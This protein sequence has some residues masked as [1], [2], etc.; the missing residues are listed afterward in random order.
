MDP[1]SRV[2]REVELKFVF[3]SSPGDEVFAWARAAA[4]VE[5]RLHAVYFDTQDLTLHREGLSVRLRQEDG[6]LIQTVKLR[7]GGPGAFGRGEWQAAVRGPSLDLDKLAATPAEQALAEGAG[8]EPLVD[9]VTHRR[10]SRTRTRGCSVELALDHGEVAAGGRTAR[11]D[12]LELE[13]KSGPARSLFAFANTLQSRFDLGLSFQSKSD[14]G[15]AL[16]Q[17]GAAKSAGF[18]QPWL[19]PSATVGEVFRAMAREC[20]E[21]I[22]RNAELFHASPAPEA[23]HQMRI[24]A[25]R[26]RALIQMFKT[27]TAD[28]RQQA[29]RAEVRWLGRELADARDLDVFLQGAWARAEARAGEAAASEARRHFELVRLAAYSRAGA[30]AGGPRL[31]RLLMETLAWIEVGPWT[32]RRAAAADHRDAPARDFAARRL[33]KSRRNLLDAGRHLQRLSSEKRHEARIEAKKLRY[34][35]EAL[36]GLFPEASSK[37]SAFV[38]RLKALQDDLGDLIDIATAQRLAADHPVAARLFGKERRREKRLL[39]DA[40]DHLEALA[41][42]KRFWKI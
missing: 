22:A 19:P 27:A 20:V 39:R 13:L 15:F 25:R 11:F 21:L 18:H 12:E 28:A 37:A 36:V 9:V 6:G 4:P 3:E 29:V 2:P 32:G 7:Q 35:A 31:R 42:E 38:A 23:I 34:G 30:A 16:M 14:R 8:L 1:K 5:T 33:G 10:T 17:A 41:A 24:G 40:S 26:L